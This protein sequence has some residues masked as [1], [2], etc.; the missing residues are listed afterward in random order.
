MTNPNDTVPYPVEYLSSES[1]LGAG[2][3]FESETIVVP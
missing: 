1:E 3:A 2:Q